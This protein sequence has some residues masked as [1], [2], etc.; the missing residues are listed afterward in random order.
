MFLYLYT[1]NT[2]I[3]KTRIK[4]NSYNVLEDKNLAIPTKNF[5]YIK[6]NTSNIF[7]KKQKKFFFTDK[8]YNPYH[9]AVT[10]DNNPFKGETLNIYPLNMKS[11][12][13]GVF[14]DIFGIVN[15][16]S[17]ISNLTNLDVEL[18]KGHNIKNIDSIHKHID[19][20]TPDMYLKD[21][22]RQEKKIS[23]ISFDEAFKI[24][25]QKHQN[26]LLIRNNNIKLKNPVLNNVDETELN[27]FLKNKR[28]K[29]TKNK[30]DDD[31][32]IKETE[33]SKILKKNSKTPQN[34][35]KKNKYKKNILSS[36]PKAEIDEIWNPKTQNPKLKY[37]YALRLNNK[38]YC[39]SK[40]S[41]NITE[42]KLTK[43]EN[44]DV[45]QWELKKKK[46]G[47]F[48]K[49]KK[50]K[51]CLKIVKHKFVKNKESDFYKVEIGKCDTI[52]GVELAP[53]YDRSGEFRYS[54]NV[55]DEYED[56]IHQD[57]RN[58]LSYLKR[59]EKEMEIF[60]L[61]KSKKY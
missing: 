42:C 31:I 4:N 25:P 11:Y 60:N 5:P 53:L 46:D 54:K 41:T 39:P 58:S 45:F 35:R 3:A 33:F 14:K 51:K 7:E 32:E 16:E 22:K 21:L 47:I 6:R 20:L 57:Y 48:I 56:D 12:K 23:D 26:E 2:L 44:A 9:I 30:K 50:S 18:L 59:K 40:K 27:K 24:L 29:N 8:A 17:I 19:R 34:D 38:F 1:V 15:K 36:S 43:N 37:Y 13:L 28:K 49:S 55:L 52:W 10:L 61:K